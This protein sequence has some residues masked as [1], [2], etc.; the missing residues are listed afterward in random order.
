[1]PHTAIFSIARQNIPVRNP[2]QCYA[3][4]GLELIPSPLVGIASGSARV[5]QSQFEVPAVAVG[6]Q[7]NHVLAQRNEMSKKR[8]RFLFNKHLLDFTMG[9][10]RLSPSQR[11]S[12]ERRVGTD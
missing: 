3:D 11:R 8:T 5:G 6:D 12:E 9:Y 4:N 7:C 1:M 10:I 2:F